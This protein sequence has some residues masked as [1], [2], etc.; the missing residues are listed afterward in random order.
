PK[1]VAKAKTYLRGQ[2][3]LRLETPDALAA[4]LAEI[5]FFGLPEN[6]LVTYR[7]RVAAVTP[8]MA[9]QAAAGHMPVPDAVA[10]VVVGKAA[11]IK[12]PLEADF[13][14]VR[15]VGPDACDTLATK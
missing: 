15:V 6:E 12:A 4:R 9:S 8:A 1:Q 11:D 5:E 14:P 7:S 13:G 3:P 2:F 10:I